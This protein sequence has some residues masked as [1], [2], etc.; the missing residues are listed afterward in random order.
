MS[1]ETN[2]NDLAK[3][4]SELVLRELDEMEARDIFGGDGGWVKVG[5]IEP[6]VN[7]LS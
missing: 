7:Q 1:N 6:A 3:A 2:V 5:P 4:A